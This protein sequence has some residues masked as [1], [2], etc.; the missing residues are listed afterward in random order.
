MQIGDVGPLAASRLG[1]QPRYL[2]AGPDPAREPDPPREKDSR[3]LRQGT[4]I[5]PAIEQAV[6]SQ[7]AS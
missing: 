1:L 2:P 4:E 3:F 5:S 6:L 7:A